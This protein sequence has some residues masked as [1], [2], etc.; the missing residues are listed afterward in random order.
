MDKTYKNIASLSSLIWIVFVDSMG[1]GIAFSVFAALFFNEQSNIL[2][3]TVSA[4]SR[5]M[6]YEFLLAIY[7]VFMFFFAPVLGGIADRFGRKP[8]LVISVLGLTL[9]FIL[10]ALGCYWSTIWLLLL[11][12]IISGIT[13]GSLSV[14]QA[15]A[16]DVST[17]SNKAFNLSLMMFSNALGFSLGPVIGGLFVHSSFAPIGTTTFLIGAVMSI[18]GFL[19]IQL[20]FNE[21]YV[22]SKQQDKFNIIKDFLNIK[23]A[24]GKPILKNYLYSVL[25]SMIGFGLFFSNIPIFLSRQFDANSTTTGSILSAEAIVFSVALMFGGKFLFAIF[26][27]INVVITTQLLQFLAYALLAFSVKSYVI[28]VVLFTLISASTG[29]MYIGLLTLISDNAEADWQGRIMG[30]VAA[31]SSVTWGVGPLLTG[32]ANHFGIGIAFVLSSMLVI[33]ALV[34][35]QSLNRCKLITSIVNK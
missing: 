14:A 28:N 5:Y 25:F 10:C 7:S 12:R 6:L 1:W 16:V 18:V 31:L 34:V 2:A 23:I 30:V 20:F 4:Q 19:G 22:P 27:K 21:T 33:S 9:G 13:A 35:L 32:A 15:A 17:E 3:S 11:G 29:I 8:A 26:K 24:F